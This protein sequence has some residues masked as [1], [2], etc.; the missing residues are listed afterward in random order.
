MVPCPCTA[1]HA[2]RRIV[3]TG[4]P[5]A[6]KTAVLEL[7]R[8][9]FCEHVRVL[10]EAAGVILGGGFPREEDAECRRAAQRA[11]F[12]VQ[13]ELEHAADGHRPALTLCDRGT[14]D[15]LAY[16]PGSAGEFLSSFATTEAEQLARYAAVIHLR[17]P[18]AH[19]GYNHENPL[20]T[21]SATVAAAIDARILDA[22]RRHPRRSIVES[23]ADFLVKAAQAFEIL[24]AEMPS[25]CRA[26]VNQ[27]HT[28]I[29]RPSCG[30]A[31]RAAPA[32]A[33]SSRTPLP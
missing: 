30:A 17:T 13:R 29:R 11:I 3:V 24:I 2:T 31:V 25:C 7:V 28:G 19:Q 12:Y 5:G 14:L 18:A 16:W 32:N 20:R 4:G 9:S 33:G 27:A 8:Q 15:G 10:P 23:S 22:W 26:R 6:G 1:T 21:E